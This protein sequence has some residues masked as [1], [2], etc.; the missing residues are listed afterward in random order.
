MFREVLKVRIKEIL[1]IK[2]CILAVYYSPGKCY[3]FSI[4]DE[5]GEVIE[6]SE[7]F[8]TSEAAKEKGKAV[9][10]TVSR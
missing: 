8:Y 2:G 3:Q 7:I 10:R 6:S 4:V 1:V 9:I 5:R